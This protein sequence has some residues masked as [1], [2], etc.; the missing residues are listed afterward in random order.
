MRAFALTIR[1]ISVHKKLLISVLALAW[2]V[3]VSAQEEDDDD[4]IVGAA[5]LGYLST[6][7][8]TD[9]TNAN[10]AFNLL[11]KQ[12]LWSHDFGVSA[13]KAD[14]SGVTTAE[15]YFAGYTARR[16]I[17]EK[18]YLFGALDWESDKFSAYDNQVSETIGYGRHLI[19]TSRHVL[20]AEVGVGARQAELRNGIT[21]DDSIVRGV[22]DYSWLISETASFKQSLVIEHGSSNTTTETVSEL[23]ADIIG[24]IALVLS[25]RIRNN[26]DLPVL[27]VG[28]KS[29]DRFTAISLEYAF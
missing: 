17:G 29:T 1:R 11:W 7:G 23:R 12:M 6:S 2:A 22:L 9:S 19:A 5:S 24:N 21:Q 3:N 28:L 26:S 15:A 20:D 16:S 8:N 14:N 25:L 18:S 4:P 27:P 10:A 13:I